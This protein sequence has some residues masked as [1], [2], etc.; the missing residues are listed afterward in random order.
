MGRLNLHIRNG[1]VGGATCRQDGHNGQPQPLEIKRVPYSL[2]IQM[3]PGFC[4]NDAIYC[5]II[6]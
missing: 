2:S 6:G 3:N 4:L 1:F 5:F